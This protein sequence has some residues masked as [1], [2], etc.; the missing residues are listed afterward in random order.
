MPRYIAF[1]RALNVGNHLVKMERLRK[2]FEEMGHGK[3]ETFIASGNVIF[4]TSSKNEEALRKK[5][6]TRLKQ[7][8]G[9]E[10]PAFLRTD[11][12]VA[13]IAAHRAFPEAETGAKKAGVF[14]A[15]LAARPSPEVERALLAA[16][17]A[18]DDFEFHGR[19]LHW[20]CRGSFLDSK[21]SGPRLEKMLGTRTTVRNS[22]T[23]RKI[24]AKYPPR[25]AA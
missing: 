3:V 11:G 5:I 18:V 1:L 23:V 22:T 15:F 7:T 6:E 19:E 16:K 17:G 9:Y 24:A 20:L 12:Q 21:F 10:V 14:V 25:G 13:E 2:V 8:L 4:E